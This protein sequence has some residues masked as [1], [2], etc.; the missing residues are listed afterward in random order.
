[1][2]I[3]THAYLSG[4]PHRIGYL[5]KLYQHVLSKPGVCMWTGGQIYDWYVDQTGGAR[6]TT[7]SR[8]R[9]PAAKR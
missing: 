8:R 4:A 9:K 2:A 3:S 7:I 6:G 1:M 5:E